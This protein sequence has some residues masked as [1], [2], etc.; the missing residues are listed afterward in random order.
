MSRENA[1]RRLSRFKDDNDDDDD[2]GLEYSSS[3]H[4]S[5]LARLRSQRAIPA[6]LLFTDHSLSPVDQPPD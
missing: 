5:P 2:N 3:R 6:P 1:A 4:S